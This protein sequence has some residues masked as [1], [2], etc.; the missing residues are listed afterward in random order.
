MEKTYKF[1]G[2]AA[3]IFKVLAWIL[4]TLGVIFSFSIFIVGGT[5]ET[6]R[7][8]GVIILL[9]GLMYFLIAFTASE[10]ITL[11]L[12]LKNKLEKGQNQ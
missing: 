6:P 10:V 4:L 9:G 1:L 12:D 11:L 5:P 3:T 2:T 7:I 8:T